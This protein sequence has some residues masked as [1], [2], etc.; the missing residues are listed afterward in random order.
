MK[1]YFYIFCIILVIIFIF[2]YYGY[3][4][5]FNKKIYFNNKKI[6]LRRLNKE[7]NYKIKNEI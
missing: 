2:Y 4:I 6:I 1:F 7:K 3:N 5:L